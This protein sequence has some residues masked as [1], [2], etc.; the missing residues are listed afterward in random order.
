MSSKL[1]IAFISAAVV[2]LGF[3][4]SAFSQ[5]IITNSALNEEDTYS[6]FTPLLS[7]QEII[8]VF[9][10]GIECG[11]SYMLIVN[12]EFEDPYTFVVYGFSSGDVDKLIKHLSIPFYRIVACYTME[13]DINEQIN[14]DHYSAESP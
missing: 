9:N 5:E 11:A 14:E 6:S 10:A 7:K 12:W 1:R 3:C 13:L 8:E 2:F 4:G